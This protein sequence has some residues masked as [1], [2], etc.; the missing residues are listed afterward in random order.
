MKPSQVAEALGQERNAVKLQMWRM[1][2]SGVLVKDFN[3]NYAPSLGALTQFGVQVNDPFAGT[4]WSAA[5]GG[6][7]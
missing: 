1:E 3:G 2:K 4:T 5:Q 7:A 6:N